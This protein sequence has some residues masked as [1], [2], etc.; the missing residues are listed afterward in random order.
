MSRKDLQWRRCKLGGAF[1]SC[2]KP[3]TLSYSLL[4]RYDYCHLTHCTT[5]ILPRLLT[6]PTCQT[7][8]FAVNEEVGALWD[9][10]HFP[11]PYPPLPS[12]TL[13]HRFIL[14]DHEILQQPNTSGVPFA[15]LPLILYN[16]FALCCGFE[17]LAQHTS[18]PKEVTKT[19]LASIE[20]LDEITSC[21][22]SEGLPRLIA[23]SNDRIILRRLIFQMPSFLKAIR[24]RFSR[25]FFFLHMLRLEP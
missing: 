21:F 9:G 10:G 16:R 3:A 14:A 25:S 18:H 5:S 2:V 20:V 17:V 11:G 23:T 15:R 13:L 1:S 4:I 12:L 22:H 8:E 19:F 7:I 24:K 6:A